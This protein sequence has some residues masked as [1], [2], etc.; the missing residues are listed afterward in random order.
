MNNHIKELKAC[1]FLEDDNLLYRIRKGGIREEINLETFTHSISAS[2]HNIGFIKRWNSADDMLTYLTM[3][4]SSKL[5]IPRPLPVEMQKIQ[6][7]D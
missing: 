1:G 6:F 3:S 2:K 4:F 5:W 7:L